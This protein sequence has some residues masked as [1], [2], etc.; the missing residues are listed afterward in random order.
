VKKQDHEKSGQILLGQSRQNAAEIPSPL[1]FASD[2]RRRHEKL[3]ADTVSAIRRYACLWAAS[4]RDSHIP[5]LF[6]K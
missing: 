6:L 5:K 1:G 3:A 2:R 4:F